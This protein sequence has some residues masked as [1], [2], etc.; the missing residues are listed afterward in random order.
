MKA[1]SGEVGSSTLMFNTG[2]TNKKFCIKICQ[3]L[4]NVQVYDGQ[5]LYFLCVYV[6]WP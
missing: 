6:L 3:N 4:S 2:H 1:F 5:I